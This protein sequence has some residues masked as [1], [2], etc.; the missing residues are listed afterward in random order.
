MC[1]MG[2]DEREVDG[3]VEGKERLGNKGEK[4]CGGYGEEKG[5]VE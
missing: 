3:G 4:V 2:S 5:H 1:K